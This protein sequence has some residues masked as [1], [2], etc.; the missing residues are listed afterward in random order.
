M[1][2]SVILC[3]FDVSDIPGSHEQPQP[4]LTQLGYHRIV[5]GIGSEFVLIES[6]SLAHLLS[7]SV[8]YLGDGGLGLTRNRTQRRPYHVDRSISMF[9]ILTEHL[10]CCFYESVQLPVLFASNS[11]LP[12]HGCDNVCSGS[13]TLSITEHSNLQIIQQSSPKFQLYT[14][15]CTVTGFHTL[16]PCSSKIGARLPRIFC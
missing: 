12:S 6:S 3:I 15:P 8:W 1:G 14:L 9:S 4:T 5:N 7:K 2:L 10:I 16:S 13:K 11:P